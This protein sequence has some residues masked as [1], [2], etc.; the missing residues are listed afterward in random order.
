VFHRG[1]DRD[2][3]AGDSFLGS[4]GA[5]ESATTRMILGLDRPSAGSVTVNRRPYA[6]YRRPVYEVGTLLEA[7]GV[8][9][10]RSAVTSLR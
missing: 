4:N 9:G 8:H 1:V 10:G 2:A 3:R 6:G 7:R 5:G